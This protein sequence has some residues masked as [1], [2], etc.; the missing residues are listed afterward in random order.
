M[1]FTREQD[2]LRQILL[3]EA[4]DIVSGLADDPDI[5]AAFLTG[6]AAWGKPN[7]DGDLD[8]L[9][10]T[11]RNEGVFYKYLIPKF[12]RVPRRTELGYIPLA[13][14]QEKIDRA[15]SDQ[16]SCQ[17]IEQF[18]NG[19]ILFQHEAW[20]DRIAEAC[21]MVSPGKML[22]GKSIAGLRDLYETLEGV[23]TEG[24]YDKA[25]LASR[26]IL[27]LATRLLLLARNHV[28]IAKEKQEF[29]AVLQTFADN[30]IES[31]RA[32]SDIKDIDQSSAFEVIETAIALISEVLSEQTISDRIVS[33]RGFHQSTAEQSVTHG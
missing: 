26:R 32:V 27:S 22:I 24:Q 4:T 11:G 3:N 19:R 16:I 8:I 20:G 1:G 15:Y 5:L 10:I 17:T 12:C 18:K 29:K 28:G 25:I 14:V 33:Y 23:L 9:L 13:V 7:P 30:E 21:R 2:R 6:S 31:Y